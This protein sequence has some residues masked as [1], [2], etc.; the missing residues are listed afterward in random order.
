VGE[1]NEN[2]VYLSL[3]DVG[4]LLHAMK[5]YDMGPLALLPIR[6]K[7]CCGFLSPL[8]VHCLGRTNPQ[9]LGPVASTLTTTPPRLQLV[10][11]GQALNLDYVVKNKQLTENEDGMDIAEGD[12]VEE[13]MGICQQRARNEV[14]SNMSN[15]VLR[16]DKDI[17]RRRDMG[18]EE[19]W[20]QQ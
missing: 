17:W 11:E 8:E 14:S 15:K 4:Y 13:V 2:L 9:P 19:S 10:M 20:E 12:S 3:W 7:V 6:R 1:G 18:T 5:S 16:K